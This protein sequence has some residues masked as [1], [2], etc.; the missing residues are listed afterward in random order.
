MGIAVQGGVVP[1]YDVVGESPTFNCTRD[2]Y[3]A[4]RTGEIAWA[5]VDALI[6]ECVPNS[7][8]IPGLYPGSARLF[9]QSV[10]V[11]PMAEE[12]DAVCSGSVISYSKAVATIRYS[13]KLPY[14]PETLVTRKW[15]FTGEFLTIPAS[16]VKWDNGDAVENEEISAA[17]IIPMIEHALTLHKVLSI[18]WT[19]IKDCIGKVNQNAINDSIFDS[20]AAEQ[21]L[22]MG[23]SIDWKLTT[24]GN[25]EWTIE[26]RFQERKVKHAA[27]E[28]GWNHFWRPDK[29]RWEKLKDD[30]GDNIYPKTTSFSSLF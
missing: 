25:E 15:S 17:K 2:E 12:Q 8:A 22:Y 24:D 28:Y 30:N 29:K 10:D 13:T 27:N 3:S 11:K 6:L 5:N 20:V 9:V 4:T 14:N 18:P 26:H 23:A 16:S 19:T 1:F 21:L 7:P